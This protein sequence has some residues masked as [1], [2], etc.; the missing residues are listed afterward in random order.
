MYGFYELYRIDG[1]SHL[2]IGS[3]CAALTAAALVP[4]WSQGNAQHDTG[5]GITAYDTEGTEAAALPPLVGG[6][7]LAGV[8]R[9]DQRRGPGRRFLDSSRPWHSGSRLM[10]NGGLEVV[11]RSEPEQNRLSD[12]ENAA[13]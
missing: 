2:C 9:L 8:R 7:R 6:R 13:P 3:E 5:E 10:A 4:N 11:N 12:S 1:G